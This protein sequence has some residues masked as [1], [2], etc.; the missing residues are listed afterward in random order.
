[1]RFTDD[2]ILNLSA[3]AATTASEILDLRTI[4][5]CSVQ[6]KWTSTTASFTV[7]LEVSNDGTNFISIDSATVLDNNGA[8]IFVIQNNPY[9]YARIYVTRTSGTL[10][11]LTAYFHGM[12]F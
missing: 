4:L 10:T 11:T 5:N 7:G 8:D 3:Q 12:G 6:I 1:M 9:K 2:R